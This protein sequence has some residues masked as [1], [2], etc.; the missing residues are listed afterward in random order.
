[1]PADPLEGRNLRRYPPLLHSLKTKF[2]AALILLVGVV[3]GLSTWWTL[4]LHTS[5]MIKATEDKVRALAEAIDGGIQVA[6]REGHNT[7]IQRI[8]EAMARDPD[9]EHIVIL[10]DNGKVRQASKP[11]LV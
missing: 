2:V 8:L 7:E 11:G 6:M 10:D 5:H 1:M 3:L 4:S 9:I